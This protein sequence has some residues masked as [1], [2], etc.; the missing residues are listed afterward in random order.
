MWVKTVS[1]RFDQQDLRVS[2]TEPLVLIHRLFGQAG[3]DQPGAPS[4]RFSLALLH[5]E[6]Q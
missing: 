3:L 1:W 6:F 5:H 2:R 4:P